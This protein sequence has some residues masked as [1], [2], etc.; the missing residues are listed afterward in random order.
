MTQSKPRQRVR[1]ARRSHE[2][3]GMSLIEVLIAVLIMVVIAIGLLP[4]FNRS[5]RQNRDGSNY[6]EL[7]NVARS[8]L[9]EYSQLDFNAQGLA[10]PAGQTMLLRH[11]YWSNAE[12]R[13]LPLPDPNNPPAT[14]RWQRSVQIEQ[15]TAG[16][17]VEDRALDD[18]LD[19]DTPEEFVHLKRIRVT[20]RPRWTAFDIFGR[21]TPIALQVVKTI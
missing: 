13:W 15:F 11:E 7:T 3:A 21:P 8:T 5:I 14:A 10:V 18:P 2:Q 20:V 4:L 1:T 6:M 12:S 17:L 16:D 19:G 9:E